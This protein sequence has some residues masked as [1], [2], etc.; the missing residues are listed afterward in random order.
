MSFEIVVATTPEQI[1]IARAMFRE[2]EKWLDLSLCF[3]GFEEELANLPGKYAAENDGRLWLAYVGD[4]PVGCVA[5]RK[6]EGVGEMKRL[7]L[8]ESARGKGIGVALIETLIATAKEIGYEKLR[9]DTYPP[10]M[11]KAVGLYESHGFRE[12]PPY[13][14]NP[15]AETLFMELE[16]L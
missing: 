7:Y 1:E 3:Q 6:L 11:A 15:N 8:R 14:E 9:L 10:K 2:Y 12:I 13:Y 4:E 16:L 5:L